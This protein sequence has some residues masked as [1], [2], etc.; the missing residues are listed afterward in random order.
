MILQHW[1]FSLFTISHLLKIYLC[2]CVCILWLHMACIMHVEVREQLSELVSSFFMWH[3]RNELRP[4][5]LYRKHV[6]L[7]SHLANSV[8]LF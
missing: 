2:V 6:C 5:G 4:V 7:L 1:M 3:L 8:S